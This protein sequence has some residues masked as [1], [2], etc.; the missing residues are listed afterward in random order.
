M[1]KLFTLLE[2]ELM[3]EVSAAFVGAIWLTVTNI[4]FLL[5]IIRKLN[6]GIWQ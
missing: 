3:T 5:L 6:T 1:L 2:S 4:R